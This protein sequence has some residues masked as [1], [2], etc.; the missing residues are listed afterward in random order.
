MSNS[1]TCGK[2]DPG[3]KNLEPGEFRLKT[4]IERDNSFSVIQ[5]NFAF[6]SKGYG[7]AMS[8]EKCFP[9]L[10]LEFIYVFGDGGLGDKQQF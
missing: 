7:I 6:R 4:F 2:V 9:K 5:T 8:V 1:G 10:L 3:R